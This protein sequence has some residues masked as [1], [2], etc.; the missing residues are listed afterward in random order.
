MTPLEIFTIWTAVSFVAGV[1]VG[2]A[3]ALTSRVDG[4]V[5]L[6]GS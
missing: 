3:M 4:R 6:R 1:I 5:R 2:K